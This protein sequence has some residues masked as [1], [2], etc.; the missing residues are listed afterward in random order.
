VRT[1]GETLPPHFHS[2]EVGD[3]AIVV[4]RAEH[5]PFDLREVIHHE[6]SAQVDRGI[7]ALHIR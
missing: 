3:E 7:V 6:G 2:I 4:I 5:K 1:E